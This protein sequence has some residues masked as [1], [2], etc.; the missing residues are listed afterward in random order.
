[1]RRRTE[2][3]PVFLGLMFLVCAKLIDLIP[4]SGLGSL[5][6]LAAGALAGR[7]ELKSTDGASASQPSD[8]KPVRRRLAGD[9]TPPPRYSRDFTTDKRVRPQAVKPA[10]DGKADHSTRFRTDRARGIRK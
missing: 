3:D 2:T 9:E 1:M 5:T 4:N 7:L 8:V 10:R 6:W